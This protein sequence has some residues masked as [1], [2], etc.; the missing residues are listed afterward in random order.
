MV[1]SSSIDESIDQ[2]QDVQLD[3]ETLSLEVKD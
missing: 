3:N 1:N 2:Y